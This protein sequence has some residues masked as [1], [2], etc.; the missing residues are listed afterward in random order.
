MVELRSTKNGEKL[1]DEFSVDPHVGHRRL[2]RLL[3][4]LGLDLGPFFTEGVLRTSKY[5][6]DMYIP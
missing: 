3:Q 6:H 5:G 1:T 4:E 2:A